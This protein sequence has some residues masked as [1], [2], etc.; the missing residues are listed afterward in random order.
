MDYKWNF[1]SGS[2]VARATP[3]R[4]RRSGEPD[5]PRSFVVFFFFYAYHAAP[6]LACLAGQSSSLAYLRR[7]LLHTIGNLE[8]LGLA[9]KQPLFWPYM[10]Q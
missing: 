3:A 10:L 8:H 6:L 7:F 9:R 5:L 1:V 2:P 4:S